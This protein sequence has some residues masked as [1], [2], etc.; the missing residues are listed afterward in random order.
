VTE[1]RFAIV[2]AGNIGGV[3]AQA[4]KAIPDTCIRVVCDRSEARAQA[5]ADICGTVWVSEYEAAVR[6]ADVDVVC[7]CTPSGTHAEVAE[8]AA[9]AGKH[10]VIE[11]PIDITLERVDRIVAAGREAAVKM[12]CI[13]PARFRAGVLQAKAALEA[14]RL[15]R[16]VMADAYVKWHRTQSYYEGSW[17]GTWRLDG[18]GALMN[19]SIHTVDLLQW[20][21][22]PVAAVFGYARALTHAIETEDTACAVVSFTNGAM[23]VIQGSTSCWP[24]DPARL[25]LRGERGTIV[26]EE[27]RIVV[28]HLAD[29]APGEEAR[30]LEIEGGLGSGSRDPLG[31]SYELHRRQ[32]ADLVEAIRDDRAPAVAGEE[33]RKAVEIILAIYRAARS[34]A[35]VSL[36]L[37]GP[38]LSRDS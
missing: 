14:G 2:G 34:G 33:G 38:E 7:V 20:L 36:P 22:G 27:G 24:G 5:L 12:T 17:R 16:L 6:R 29:A 15:G 31:I 19:Q 21:A 9:R 4:I 3:H 23:G 26:L 25:E 13:F 11:K 37:A 28:W 32:L 1:V 10:V 30:M 8:A 35:P 18:G